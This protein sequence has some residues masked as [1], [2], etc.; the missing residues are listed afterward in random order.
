MTTIRRERSAET[1]YRTFLG[2]TLV[3]LTCKA[4]HSCPTAARLGRLWREARQ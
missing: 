3:C 2:H 4:G 1:A